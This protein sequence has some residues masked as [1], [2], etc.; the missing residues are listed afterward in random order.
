MRRIA[1]YIA[2]LL[3][4]VSAAGQSS[5]VLAAG[6]WWKMAVEEDGIYRI[7][8]SDLPALNG[9]RCEGLAVYGGR[10][11]ALSTNN[12]QTTIGDLRQVGSQIVDRNGNGIFDPGDELLFYAEGAE[13]W[14]YSSA[15]GR[16]VF[17]HHPYARQNFYYLTASATDALRIAP[18]SG[19]AAD[20]VLRHHSVVTHVN[21]D[22]VNLYE[23]G[24]QWMGERFSTAVPT[25][26]FTLRLP[27]G[28]VSDV[29]LR[30]ALAS[31]AGVDGRFTV[32]TQGYSR[33][34]TIN[35][36]SVYSTVEESLPQA[37]PTYTF[38][39]AYSCSENA[40]SGYLDYIELCAQAPIAFGG[41][42]AIV[43]GRPLGRAAA[44][45]QPSGAGGAR[46]WEVTR[47]GAER[48]LTISPDGWSDSTHEARKYILF[49]GTYYLTPTAITPLANQ[50]LHGSPQADLVIVT[51]PLFRQQAGKLAALHELFDGLT[52]LVATDEEVYNEYSTGMQDPMAIRSLLRWLKERHPQAPPRYL[53]LFGK[54][55]YDNRNLLGSD[56]PTVVTY[57]TPHSFDDDGGSYASDDM[58]GYLAPNG[59]GVPSE[60]LDV[61]VGRLP[62]RNVGEAVLLVDKLE[63]YIT[64]RDMA[65][66]NNRGDW[67]NYVALLADD[68]DPGSPADSIF[69]HSSEA[70]ASAIKQQFPQLNIDRLYADAYRQASGAIG[71]FY[72]DLNNALRQ[73][74]NYGCLLLNYIGH[75]ST[76]YIGTERYMEASDVAGYTN[77]DRLPVFITSTCSYGRYD[78]PK[79]Q[80][81]AELC[82]LAPA[83][84][85][86]VVSASRPIS[87][88]E[89]FNKDLVLFA[90]DPANTIGDAVRMA[91]NRTYVPLCIGITGDP[92]LRLSQPRNR[93]HVTHINSQPVSDNAD[94]QAQVLSKVTVTGE[95]RDSVGQLVHDFDGTIYPVVY[96]RET[97]AYT[98]ANDNP[99]T[100]VAFMQQK[101]VLY[102]GSHTVSGGRF[103]YSFIVPMDVSYRYDYA[104]LS[105]YAKSASDH[106]SGSYLRLMLGGMSDSADVG[107]TAP[108]IRLF[109]GDTNFRTGGLV[110]HSPTLVALL[111]DSAGINTGFGLGHDI[112]AVLDDNPGS[113]VVLNDLYEADIADS[114]RG[115]VAYKFEK[116]TPG[117]HKVTLK[118]WNIFGISA[119]ASTEF[120]V[121][122][123]DT[124]VL[125]AVECVPNP[126]TEYTDISLRVNVSSR[127]E[128]ATLEIYNTR[129]QKVFEHTPEVSAEGYIVGPVRWRTDAVVSGLYLVRLLL[130]DSDGEVHQ[131][132]GKCIVY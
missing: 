123:A 59:R 9:R 6:E 20:T 54:G 30:Y 80:C 88:S 8:P 38:T 47:A 65:D 71:S 113:L 58:L 70:V 1:L 99:G 129:G 86:T 90:L 84:M 128:S 35:Y 119:T 100:E 25:R 34:T 14:T 127:I 3:A 105:H 43:R 66:E 87:H 2:T 76:A 102:K 81:G 31:V 29:K 55:S 69:A 11:G 36:R 53:I 21:N 23:S 106:A 67:R 130:T 48:E 60:A 68:A 110:G 118:A 33:Q 125:S 64:R 7:T 94:I 95:I 46:V 98:L 131:A 120:T 42:Q 16:W 18:E 39:L 77:F 109:M 19:P 62:A 92:A 57:E 96:D 75:G 41:G 4:A 28:E 89:R 51:H 49:D 56:L 15:L 101:N 132:T 32:S 82:L 52:T 103:E 108:Q 114:R 97:R 22:L 74:L 63:S 13:Q 93:V 73:R 44:T 126:A 40:A 5:S 26:T 121:R 115:M 111:Y 45:F 124:M 17:D 79:S 122:G 85:V 61:S 104:K 72:P 12:S 83:G 37:S 117:R 50:D 27:A 24:Q 78:L 10:G 91:K 112:T 116:L 107:H